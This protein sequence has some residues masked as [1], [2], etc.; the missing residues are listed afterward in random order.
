MSHSTCLDPG[1]LQ[2]PDPLW[3]LPGPR[4]AGTPPDGVLSALTGD[5]TYD[6]PHY[7]SAHY[8]KPDGKNEVPEEAQSA[9]P[10]NRVIATP[11]FRIELDESAGKSKLKFTNKRTDD[12]IVF[13][14]ESNTITIQATTAITI[15]AIGAI[16]LEATQVTIA[17]R[18]VRPIPEPI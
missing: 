12:H 10:D 13:D 1:R 15:K 18:L 11:T 3:L 9:S 6:H 4:P 14:A 5:S 17:G 7:I 2:L 8:G 16:S